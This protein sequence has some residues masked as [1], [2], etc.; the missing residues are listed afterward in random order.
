MAALKKSQYEPLL[1]EDLAC[2]R[3]DGP[4]VKNIPT[5]RA[6]LKEEWEKEGKGEKAR[7]EKK[8]K[9]ELEAEESCDH[10]EKKASDES[11]SKLE[12]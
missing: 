8:R 9:R 12:S 10:R 1:K 5:L 7:L 6:H 3:C 11:S 2:W 4:G